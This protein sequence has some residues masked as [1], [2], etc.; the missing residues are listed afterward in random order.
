[1]SV[2]L[3]KMQPSASYRLLLLYKINDTTFI[4]FKY[5]R[6]LSELNESQ[7]IKL[8]N[9]DQTKT[10]SFLPIDEELSVATRVAKEVMSSFIS[11]VR[12][13][14]QASVVP[15]LPELGYYYDLRTGSERFT[16]LR[17]DGSG[18]IVKFITSEV[19]S[20]KMTLGNVLESEKRWTTKKVEGTTD[21]DYRIGKPSQIHTIIRETV[22]LLAV[23]YISSLTRASYPGKLKGP[24]F[25]A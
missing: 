8:W 11:L 3:F 4:T 6:K 14:I 17:S 13:I 24:D 21:D 12:D 22:Y 9:A 19:Y 1:M 7:S 20:C 18:Y 10:L 16:L 15:T 2:K 5:D 23:Y 25:P